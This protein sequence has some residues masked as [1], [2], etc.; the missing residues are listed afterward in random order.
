MVEC[1]VLCPG[2]EIIRE[3]QEGT[4]GGLHYHKDPEDQKSTLVWQSSLHMHGQSAR[5]GAVAL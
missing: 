1:S 5:R 4:E 2:P 3:D